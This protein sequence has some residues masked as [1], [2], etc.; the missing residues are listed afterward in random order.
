MLIAD[1]DPAVRRLV[2]E[3][4]RGDGVE[5]REAAN[6]ADTLRQIEARRPAALVLDLAMPELD[7]FDVLERLQDDPETRTLP[8]VVLTGTRPTV[9]ERS[10]LQ[11]RG[12]A[13]LE[14]SSYSPVELRRLV[15]AAVGEE[16]LDRVEELEGAE[17][18]R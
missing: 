2:V 5:L 10:Y 9:E 16:T 4:L 17:G 12:V 18:L 15:R 1:D 3:T 7:G 6:G 11:T 13:L 8:V 14:K